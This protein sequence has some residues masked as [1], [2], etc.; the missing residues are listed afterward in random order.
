M[1]YF[2]IT[3]MIAFVALVGNAQSSE[4]VSYGLTKFINVTS[5]QEYKKS[6][7]QKFKFEGNNLFKVG[8]SMGTVANS[9]EYGVFQGYNNGNRVYNSRIKG[10]ST[11][12][13][14]YDDLREGC[15]FLVSSDLSVINEIHTNNVG[16]PA[17]VYVYERASTSKPGQLYR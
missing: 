5:G 2:L 7:T 9:Q 12:R 11:I 8:T 6:E 3:F 13:G 16:Q 14:S 10:W 15:Y 4:W 1:R 17:F